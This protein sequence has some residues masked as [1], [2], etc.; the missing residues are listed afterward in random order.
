MKIAFTGH[1]PNKLGYDYD[2]T[3]YLVLA[4][5]AKI[6]DILQYKGV[7]FYDIPFAHNDMTLIIG[8]ALGIDTLVAKIAI[9]YNIPFIAAI[10]CIGQESKWPKKSQD[11]YHNILSNKLCTKVLLSNKPYDSTCMQ[12]RN[13]WMVLKSDLLIAVW[14]KSSGGT[15]N[16]V[17]YAIEQKKEIIYINPKEIVL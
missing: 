11:I 7:I 17:K 9:E 6:I 10:P 3:S 12:N 16:C 13:E 2:L 14:D 4:I 8:M 15:A 5:K 1:R